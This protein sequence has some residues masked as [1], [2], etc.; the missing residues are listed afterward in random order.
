MNRYKN[1]LIIAAVL[2]VLA[3]IGTTMN[4]RQASAAGGGPTV[5]IDPDQR[6]YPSRGRSV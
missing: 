3:V 1:H 4:S 6:R 5:T 2:S